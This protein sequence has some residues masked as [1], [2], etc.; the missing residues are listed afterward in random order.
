M[1]TD[2]AEQGIRYFIRKNINLLCKTISCVHP[3]H[4]KEN[5]EHLLLP[6]VLLRVQEDFLACRLPQRDT[7]LNIRN[8]VT[9]I[10][11]Q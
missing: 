6:A 1:S 5:R 11:Y 7:L 8:T 10:K 2:N 3:S 9:H 4:R